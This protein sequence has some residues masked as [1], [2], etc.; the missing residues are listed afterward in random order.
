MI[1]SAMRCL[2]SVLSAHRPRRS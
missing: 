2:L 1:V